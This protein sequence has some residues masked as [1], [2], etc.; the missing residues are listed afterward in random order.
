MQIHVNKQTWTAAMKS[1]SMQH[2]DSTFLAA[3]HDTN[4]E[5]LIAS[6]NLQLLHALQEL[7]QLQ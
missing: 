3:V 2:T 4:L 1:L 5:M 7:N 6:G